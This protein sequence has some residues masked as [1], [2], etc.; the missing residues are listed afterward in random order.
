MVFR[1]RRPSTMAEMIRFLQRHYRFAEGARLHPSEQGAPSG[2]PASHTNPGGNA[3][4]DIHTAAKPPIPRIEVADYIEMGRL[5]AQWAAEPATRPGNV[6]DLKDA[7][8]R[9]RRRAGPD[10]DRRVRPEHARPPD[11]APAGRRR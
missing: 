3:M 9:H 8:R 10:Q 4:L 11:P 2:A 6:A 7:A 1:D 5:V